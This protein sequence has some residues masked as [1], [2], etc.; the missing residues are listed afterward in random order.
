MR[1]QFKASFERDLKG[2]K[3]K[4]LLKEV[5]QVIEEV[6]AAGTLNS[7]SHLRKLQAEGP[8]FRIRLGDYRMG[9]IVEGDLV[10]FVRFLH[11]KEIY[12]YFP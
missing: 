6:E 12:R 2:V 10:T 7:I 11:R 9:L 8:C 1:L 5:R 3:D 4:S